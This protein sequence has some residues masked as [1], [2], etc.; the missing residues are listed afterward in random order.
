MHR[1]SG[2]L[3]LP[4]DVR[5]LVADALVHALSPDAVYLFGSADEGRL[6]PDSDVDLAVLVPDPITPAQRWALT[7][8]LANLVRRD[9]DLV[10]LRRA[11]TVL[12]A[13]VV[14]RGSRLWVRDASPVA[15]FEMRALKSYALLNEERAPILERM[16]R[17]GS[18]F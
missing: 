16:Q 10:D 15:W 1:T 13:L 11:S 4:A 8:Q 5:A 12:Q 7:A 3:T 18:P 6:R 2:K 17:E 14:S 9:V